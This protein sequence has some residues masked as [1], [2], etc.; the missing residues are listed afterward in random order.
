M[1]TQILPL[2]L[3]S[4][5]ELQATPDAAGHAAPVPVPRSGPPTISEATLAAAGRGLMA[6]IGT[7]FAWPAGHL[8][9]TGRSRLAAKSDSARLLQAVARANDLFGGER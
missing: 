2:Y 6:R 4:K 3:E 1:P 8:S 7:A 5:Q 9:E